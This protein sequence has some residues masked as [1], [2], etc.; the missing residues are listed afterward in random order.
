[1]PF[2]TPTQNKN[3]T[4]FPQRLTFH[5]NAIWSRANQ[6]KLCL[7]QSLFEYA[8]SSLFYMGCYAGTLHSRT[9]M[10]V[11]AHLLSLYP[12]LGFKSS[13]QQNSLLELGACMPTQCCIICVKQP[14]I[15]SD[16]MSILILWT[17]EDTAWLLW[18][19]RRDAKGKKAESISVCVFTR[20]HLSIFNSYSLMSVA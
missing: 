13:K 16:M 12:S 20:V 9:H 4:L 7:L 6:A 2:K 5:R 10:F 14:T 15:Y 19:G 3:L 11:Y 17:F 8:F 1:M 18:R